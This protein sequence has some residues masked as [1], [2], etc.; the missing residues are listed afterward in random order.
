MDWSQAARRAAVSAGWAAA[1]FA[2]ANLELGLVDG[3]E[4]PA[5]IGRPVRSVDRRLLASRRRWP[6]RACPAGWSRPWWRAPRSWR[7]ASKRGHRCGG[8]DD[9]PTLR[10][11][12]E[13][14]AE[15]RAV[16]GGQPSYLVAETLRPSSLG[17]GDPQLSADPASVGGLLAVVDHADGSQPPTVSGELAVADMEQVP[18]ANEGCGPK[19]VAR[20]YCGMHDRASPRAHGDREFTVTAGSKPKATSG[21]SR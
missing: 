5:A 13:F 16:F 8:Q 6:V 14:A 17:R 21:A 1:T 9:R 12:E 7:P 10:T 15:H 3:A 4:L 18:V 2:Q 19:E 20:G 11:F